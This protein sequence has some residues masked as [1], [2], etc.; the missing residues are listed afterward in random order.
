MTLFHF[1]E[2]SSLVRGGVFCIENTS[3][4]RADVRHT[5]NLL[6]AMVRTVTQ[7]KQ[8]IHPCKALNYDQHDLQFRVVAYEDHH[9]KRLLTHSKWV[10]QYQEGGWILYRNKPALTYVVR[11]DII[12]GLIHIRLMNKNHDSVTVGIFDNM[13]EAESFVDEAYPEGVWDVVYANNP[14]SKELAPR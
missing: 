6:E 8:G 14:L 3:E 7:I 10:R 12:Q 13:S 4:R 9:R 2:V 5:K 1:D 11:K